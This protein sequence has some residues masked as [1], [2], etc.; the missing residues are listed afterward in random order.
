[1]IEVTNKHPNTH[2]N[3]F[4]TIFCFAKFKAVL[5]YGVLNY[6]FQNY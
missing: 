6:A 1:V 3:T 2:F 4:E 5:S